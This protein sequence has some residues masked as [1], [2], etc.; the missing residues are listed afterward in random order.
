MHLKSLKFVY[1]KL[2]PENVFKTDKKC[3]LD[4]F[5]REIFVVTGLFSLVCL[6]FSLIYYYSRLIVLSGLNLT[7]AIL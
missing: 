4:F 3:H 2:R 6:F 7:A 1:P 5:G